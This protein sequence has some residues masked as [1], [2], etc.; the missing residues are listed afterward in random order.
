MQENNPNPY[1]SLFPKVETNQNETNNDKPK[2]RF[3]DDVNFEETPIQTNNEERDSK[4][5]K[6]NR[7]ND[8]NPF[9]QARQTS[10]EEV[11]DPRIKSSKKECKNKEKQE[12]VIKDYPSAFGWFLTLFLCVIPVVGLVHIFH[13]AFNKTHM[14]AKTTF[15][16]GVLILLTFFLVIFIG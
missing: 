15:A 13:L 11:E 7:F 9:Y 16:R 8:E 1:K 5:K 2:S 3:N 12:K 6:K 4:K 10:G 14:K